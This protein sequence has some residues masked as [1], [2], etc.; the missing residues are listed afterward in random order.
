MWKSRLFYLLGSWILMLAALQVIP[1]LFALFVGEDAAAGSFFASATLALLLGGA[2]FLGFRSTERVRVPRLTIFLPLT[3]VTALAVMAG[4]PLFLLF[5]ESGFLRAFYDG[6][7]QITTNGSTAYEGSIEGIRSIMLW[8]ALSSWI[9]G[10]MAISF[11]L[12]LL[13]AMN[14]GGLQLHRSPLHFGDRES[15]YQ[16]LRATTR[17]VAPI[18]LFATMLAFILFWLT[19]TG[20]FDAVLLA[21]ASVS[22]AG[23]VPEDTVHNLGIFSQVILIIFLIIGLSNWDFHHWRARTFSPRFKEDREL[24]LSL[25]WIG[26]GA[27]LLFALTD[28]TVLELVSLVLAA[29]SALA[30]F[31]VMPPEIA[32]LG[33]REALPV[34]ILLMILTVMGGAVAS[35]TGGLR[36]MRVWLI[37]KMGRAEVDRL[38]HPHGVH[39]VQYGNATAEKRDLDAVWLLLGSFVLIMAVG[40][41]ALA[42]LGIHFQDALTLSFAAMTLSGPLATSADPSF[43]GYSSLAQVDY[44]ILSILML[45]GRVEAPIFMAIFAKALWRG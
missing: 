45:I 19:G 12:S 18:Y 22:T 4:L 17:A 3:G 41:M 2:L 15:G 5:P 16:R 10:L 40:A 7:S 36:Q 35:A 8:R 34:A 28:A 27:A 32:E 23:V 44:A 42:V 11:T 33:I 39:T 25:L 24:R 6:M 14:S 30:T 1:L 9:G 31:G 26:I 37:F 29:A 21:L 38:A 20:R 13:M 43:A